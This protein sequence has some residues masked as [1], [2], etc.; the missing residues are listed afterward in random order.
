MILY[1]VTVSL[2]EHLEREWVAWQKEI[3]IPEVLATGFFTQHQM[4]KLIEPV[5]EVGYV[6]YNILYRLDSLTALNTY[7]EQFAPGLQRK[8]LERFGDQVFAVRA[9]MEICS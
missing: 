1:S 7:R 3:H 9:V 5:M 6:T 2:P 8:H 4:H